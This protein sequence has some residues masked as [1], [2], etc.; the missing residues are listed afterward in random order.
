MQRVRPVDGV[1]YETAQ[2]NQTILIIHATKWKTC[3]SE[4]ICYLALPVLNPTLVQGKYWQR[5]EYVYVSNDLTNVVVVSTPDTKVSFQ[6]V[7][8]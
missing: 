3:A 6:N 4:S 2:F 7:R 5:F 8:L 1:R